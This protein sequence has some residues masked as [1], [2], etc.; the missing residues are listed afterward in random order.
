MELALSI[1]LGIGLSAA[2]GYRVFVPFLVLSI[3]ATSGH[4]TLTH[5]FEWIGTPYALAAFAIATGLEVTAYYVP[6]LDNL[7]DAVSTPA[8][9]VAGIVI[10]A[11]VVGDVSPF[12]KWTLAVIAGGGVAGAVQ[13][14]TV[15]V[16]GASTV[17]TGGVGNPVVS[18]G[19]LGGSVVTSVLSV[20]VPVVAVALVVVLLVIVLRFVRG[21][22]RS[23]R[24]RLSTCL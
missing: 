2:C 18:T 17:T 20:L 13:A 7:L 22:R 12:L 9:V 24:E 3:A 23:R 4:V 6:W 1:L 19:E 14:T 21:L 15:A 10:T 11:S 5:G 8:A 16:R